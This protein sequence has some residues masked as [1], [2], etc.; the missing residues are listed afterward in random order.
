MNIKE[1]IIAIANGIDLIAAQL[2]SDGKWCDYDTLSSRLWGEGNELKTL[3]KELEPN[4]FWDVDNPE[5]PSIDDIN[6]FAVRIMD[7]IVEAPNVRTTVSVIRSI[8]MPNREL[9]VWMDEYG[10]VKWEW[11]E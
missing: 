8:K 3:V 6:D 1:R 2:R 11:V 9:D 4:Q 7:D 10:D 5:T